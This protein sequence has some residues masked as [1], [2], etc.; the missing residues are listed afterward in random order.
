MAKKVNQHAINRGKTVA[1]SLGS[2]LSGMFLGLG[3][4]EYKGIRAKMSN[5]ASSVSI[6]LALIATDNEGLTNEELTV[7][8]VKFL[9]NNKVTIKTTQ[10]PKTP[11]S[12]SRTQVIYE[13]ID[14]PFKNS[15]NMILTEPP[16]T[17]FIIDH[18]VNAF[19]QTESTV[20]PFI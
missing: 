10:Y 1:K 11:Y 7:V 18:V 6:R 15:F 5:T 16:T 9:P 2:A 20:S 17:V 12:S 3:T 14:P 13:P 19:F 4:G 8:V